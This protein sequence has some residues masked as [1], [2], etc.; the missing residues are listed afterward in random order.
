MLVSVSSASDLVV[1]EFLLRV[2]PDLLE[3]GNAIDRINRQTEA[4]DFVV[5]RQFH[6]R[7]D[8]ALLFVSPYMQ[9]LVLA[10]VGQPM[11][12]I[13]IGVEVENNRLVDREQRIV[14]QIRQ[15]VGMFGAWLQLEQVDDVDEPDFQ[16]RKLLSQKN[17]CGQCLLC[18]YI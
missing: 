2:P 9:S 13:R 6:W 18:W 8:V 10:G 16:V 11:N 5:H 17:G 4:I 7:V 14:I 12:Q 1:S 3:F 15:P